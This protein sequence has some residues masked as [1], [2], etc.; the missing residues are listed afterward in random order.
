MSALCAC[1]CVNVPVCVHVRVHVYVCTCVCVCFEF[2]TF[3]HDVLCD[4]VLNVHVHVC[5]PQVPCG[6]CG[7]EGQADRRGTEM[8]PD[9]I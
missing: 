3:P 6:V 5:H 8:F 2:H 9:I 7:P 4:V 1:V